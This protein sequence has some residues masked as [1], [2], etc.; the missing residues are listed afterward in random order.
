[1]EGW[2]PYDFPMGFTSKTISDI[3]GVILK[4]KAKQKTALVTGGAGFIGSH[5][6]EELLLRGFK[7]LAI[8]NFATS[9]KSNISY[10]LKIFKFS[11]LYYLVVLSFFELVFYRPF[12]M[13]GQILG[14]IKFFLGIRTFDQYKKNV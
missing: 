6:C 3:I 9:S 4:R 2:S 8:D 14:T 1:M 12:V 7:V 11:Y 10:L 13:A 5:L